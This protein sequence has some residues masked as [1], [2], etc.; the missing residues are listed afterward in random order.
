MLVGAGIKSDR[1]DFK[2][3][4]DDEKPRERMLN[5]GTASVLQ[6]SELLMVL[7]KTGALGCDVG[8]MSRRLIRAF[9]GIDAL[10]RCDFLEIKQTVQEYN[11]ANP[12]KKIAGF[13]TVKML[14]LAAAFELVRR[15][16]SIET[17]QKQILN[18]KTAYVF[19]KKVFPN[20]LESERFYMLPLDSRKRPLCNP[21]CVSSGTTTRTIVSV[22]EIFIKALKWGA[23]AILVAHN[24][25]SGN[26]QPS[27]YDIG[28]TRDMLKMASVVGVPLLDH[29]ILNSNPASTSKRY[30]S[31]AEETRFNFG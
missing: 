29:L 6:A 28:I 14:E 3:L 7:L 19:F 22:K 31:L 16:L 8:E 17:E 13:G 4:P 25:P 12:H 23:G 27:K 9:G 20:Y 26:L 24:H 5:A 21:V 2:S 18:S 30:Y 1:N 10:V 11:R 15:G